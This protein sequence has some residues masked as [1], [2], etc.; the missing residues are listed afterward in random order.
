[1]GLPRSTEDLRNDVL[2]IGEELRNGTISNAVARTL[3]H[4]AKIALDTLRTEI[5]VA[6]LGC[7]FRSVDMAEERRN[8]E[9]SIRRVA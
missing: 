4:R 8:K 3:L 6:R 7:D 1:M 2:M 9:S 5:D